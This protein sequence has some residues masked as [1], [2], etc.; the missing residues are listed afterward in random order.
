MLYLE[1]LLNRLRFDMDLEKS[2]EVK[3]RLYGCGYEYEVDLTYNRLEKDADGNL[4]I[5]ADDN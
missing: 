1:D 2:A 4:I 5:I 3:L